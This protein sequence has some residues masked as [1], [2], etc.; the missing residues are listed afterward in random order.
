VLNQTARHED[1]WGSDL[2]TRWSVINFMSLPLYRRGKIPRY[3][4]HRRLDELQ[5]QCGPGG[6]RGEKF[7]VSTRIR[8]SDVQPIS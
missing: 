7:P 3:T 8:T 5:S 2:G 6:W 1:A 4:L